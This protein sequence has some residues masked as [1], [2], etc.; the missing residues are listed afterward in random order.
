MS[1]AASSDD[2]ANYKAI[3]PL[4]SAQAASGL[5]AAGDDGSLL[6]GEVE[7]AAR[8]RIQV[9]SFCSAILNC[10]CAG[11][12]ILFSIWAPIFQEKLRFTQ[13]QINAVS[14]AGELG[15][16]LP[17]PIFGWICDRYGPAK[18]S[19]LSSLFFGPSYLLAAHAFTNELPFYV[20]LVAFVFIGCG[21]SSMYFAGVTTCA[22]NFTGESRGIALALPIAA[23]GL[24][25]LWEAQF[26]SRVFHNDKVLGGIQ[27]ADAFVFF[28]GLLTVVGVLGGV[29]LRIL[30]EIGAGGTGA[31]DDEGTVGE[32]SALIGGDSAVGG[33]GTS[34]PLEGTECVKKQ[35]GWLD[36]NTREFLADRTM[37]WF[38]IGVFLVTGPGESFINNMGTLIQTLYTPE[39]SQGSIPLD[40]IKTREPIST[41][42][43]V[44]IIALT[45]TL[46][47]LLAG[48]LSDY[49]APVVPVSGA[50]AAGPA[51]KNH[52]KL[53]MSRMYLLIG[54]AVLMCFA[55]VFVA[56]GGVDQR[57]DRFWMISSAMGA[58]YGAVF[59]LAPT[60]VSVVWGVENFGTNWGIITVTPAVG[61]TAFG[62]IFAVCY[63]NAAK[64]QNPAFPPTSTIS[65][66][67]NAASGQGLVRALVEGA[68]SSLCYGRDCY[69]TA[70]WIMG[71][72]VAVA[73][74]CWV[75]A[76][77]GRGGWTD[78]RIA[79]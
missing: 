24:S 50:E 3:T 77:K 27:I 69:S 51:I 76:W 64:I 13:M 41:A 6:L 37:W 2:D 23:F 20:M 16:Y 11:S 49:L 71:A 33:Y 72:S 59:T 14:I 31:A 70:F 66:I 28:A 30:P 10:V 44:S 38:A 58:G 54:F 36:E 7:R 57:G 25:S 45:S 56:L 68:S 5:D 79:V 75:W 12:L 15:M 42:T 22:K 62:L 78:R 43:H 9:I 32:R 46:A 8:K 74:G 61:A 26:V 52:R 73:C 35:G 63:D 1:T 40:T 39:V 29:G 21:T 4:G 47:R 48:S 19:L 55:E 17:V 65:G 18:L 34:T 53:S 67:F 60:I